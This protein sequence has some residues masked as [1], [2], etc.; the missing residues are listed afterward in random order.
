[1]FGWVKHLFLVTSAIMTLGL[2][3]FEASAQSLSHDSSAKS[4]N[5]SGN[6]KSFVFEVDESDYELFHSV[7]PAGVTQYIHYDEDTAK[8]LAKRLAEQAK[9][10]SY[11]KFGAVISDRIAR[12]FEGSVLNPFEQ[13][14]AELLKNVPVEQ[15]RHMGVTEQPSSGKGEKILH[16]F[17]NVTGEDLI[18]FH[19][20]RDQ[21]PKQG[22]WFNF[23]YHIP[24]DDYEHHYSL[25]SIYW[26]KDV[27]P[28]WTA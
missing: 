28:L 17:S 2:V 15:Q 23:H 3:D 13:V 8:A 1:M 6:N 14:L 19:V 22:H 16:V 5:E 4:S 20:R 18:R 10:Q 11:Q 12:D 25:A 24:G 9:E 21:P 26:G 27:P 7:L